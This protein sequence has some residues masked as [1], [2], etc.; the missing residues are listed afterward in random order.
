MTR[1]NSCNDFGH[2]DSTIDIFVVFII[3]ITITTTIVVSVLR[4]S[5]V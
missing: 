1:V 2:N 5:S 4:C 3:N